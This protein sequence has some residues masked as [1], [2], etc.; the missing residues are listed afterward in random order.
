[1]TDDASRR[2]TITWRA[3]WSSVHDPSNQVAQ[4]RCR[5][6]FHLRLSLSI[7]A[8]SCVRIKAPERRFGHLMPHLWLRIPALICSA[9]GSPLGGPSVALHNI[10]P[11]PDKAA[12]TPHSE[13]GLYSCS[14][15]NGLFNP[16]K[17]LASCPILEG[18]RLCW[19]GGY[20]APNATA[21]ALRVWL[22]ILH[23]TALPHLQRP[24][25]F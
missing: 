20:A 23:E 22:F 25:A 10:N 15:R 21:V 8:L 19:C 3:C 14:S 9:T 17:V 12:R 6:F 2:V 16:S 13:F 24:A 18:V 11:H 4:R 5:S 7:C 1:V